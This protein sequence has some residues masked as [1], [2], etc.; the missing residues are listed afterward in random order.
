MSKNV[1][2]GIDKEML[3]A[4][5]DLHEIPMGAYNI[6]K[7]GERLSSR[8]TEEIEIVSKTDKPGIDI[9]VKPGVKNRSIHIPV[10][11]T[12]AGVSECVYNDFF[13]GDDADVV[14]IAGCG[15]HNCGD[16]D[17]QHDGIHTFH[18]GKNAKIKYVEKHYGDGDGNGRRI[19]NPVTEIYMDENSSCEMESVQIKGVDST[20]RT[21]NAHLKAG[22][23]M[24]VMERLMTHGNQIASSDMT[25]ELNGEDSSVRIISRSIARDNSKQEFHPIAVGNAACR[26]HIQ[27]DSIIMDK[28]HISSIP[29]IV[30]ND[31]MAEI[32]HEAAIGRINNDQ[33]LKLQTL[34]MSAEEAEAVIIEGFLK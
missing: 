22:A 34:G 16:Q 26:A 31:P 15:I 10:I 2:T 28:A 1:L 4:V 5:A 25:C 32:V 12:E 19:L 23:T 14:I 8:S 6:R 13:I 20:L 17:S 3:E 27:C 18:I 21:T 7:N 30:A 29:E 33:L 11:I 24:Q 9:I